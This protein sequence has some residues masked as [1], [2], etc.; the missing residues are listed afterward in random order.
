[1]GIEF[2]NTPESWGIMAPDD[3]SDIPWGRCLDE[4]AEAGYKWV[5]LGPYGYLPTDPKALRA[6]LDARSLQLAAGVAMAPLE[7]PAAWPD[8]ES[9]VLRTG[10]LL[11][12][13]GARFLNLIDDVY[14][15]SPPPQTQPPERLDDD[16]W[17]RL[18][19][20]TERVVDLTREKFDLQVAFH[21]C[22]ETHVEYED[23]IEALLDQTD[24]D[25]LSLCLDT[26]HHAYRGGDP[27]DF[28]R[29]RHDRI[30]YLHLKSVNGDLQRRANAENIPLH[31]AV[32]QGVFCEPA[33]GSVDF[34][35]LGAVLQQV[36]W[37]G[38]AMVEQDMFHPPHDFP[39]PN[40]VRSIEHYRSSGIG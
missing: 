22:A 24:P 31:S 2:G 12:A 1:M 30:S 29:R 13:T 15:P 33:K 11:A 7:E 6:E 35:G 16:A 8:L 39:L 36:G 5:E 14:S 25:R 23:E 9:Q 4:I 20:T 19:E 38:I 32:D 3:P 17:E 26:G 28:F 40:A 10:E 34:A 21:P 18:I 27:V 37:S